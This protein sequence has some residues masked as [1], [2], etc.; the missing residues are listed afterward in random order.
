MNKDDRMICTLVRGLA[1]KAVK[2]EWKAMGRQPQYAEASELAAA[3]NVYFIEHK[4]ELVR[5]ARNHPVAIQYRHQERMRLARKA[6]IA[7]IR[8]KGRRVN[9]IAPE[10]LNKLIQRYLQDHPWESALEERGCV[11]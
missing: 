6:V 2:A 9:S 8:E 4:E 1:R 3:T 7:E 10:E 5:E 11:S